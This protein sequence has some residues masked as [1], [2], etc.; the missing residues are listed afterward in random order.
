MALLKLCE[1][2]RQR[3]IAALQKHGEIPHRKDP[4]WRWSR[5]EDD[6]DKPGRGEG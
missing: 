6:K 4:K 3:G 5:Q 1:C 2:W